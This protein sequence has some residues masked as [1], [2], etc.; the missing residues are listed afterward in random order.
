MPKSLLVGIVVLVIAGALIYYAM[1]GQT[2]VGCEVCIEFNGH[3]QCRSAKAAN[4]QD[5][6]RT[7]TDTACADLASGM[8]E[9]MSCGRTTPKST[10]C[11]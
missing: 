8:N 9:S 11:E 2:A 6:I 1:S 5:S 10:K 4:K 7:A 3:T